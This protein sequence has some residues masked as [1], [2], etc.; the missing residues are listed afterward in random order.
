MHRG[1]VHG[2]MRRGCVPG[3]CVRVRVLSM[4][5]VQGVSARGMPCCGLHKAESPV[6]PRRGTKAVQ[7]QHWQFVWAGFAGCWV[8]LAVCP[9][10]ASH[11]NTVP[12][13]FVEY[14]CSADHLACRRSGQLRRGAQ[15]EQLRCCVGWHCVVAAGK[16]HT[17]AKQPLPAVLVPPR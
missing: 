17:G 12:C 8:R 5:H 13:C 4:W 15:L 3:G 2:G 11:I 9:F 6:A 10:D 1:D 7:Q 16:C 14:A